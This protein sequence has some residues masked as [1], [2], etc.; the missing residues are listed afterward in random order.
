[1][2]P[3]DDR[4]MGFEIFDRAPSEKWQPYIFLVYIIQQNYF[5]DVMTY[6][7]KLCSNQVFRH[8]LVKMCRYYH[9]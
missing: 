6:I 9:I 4:N 5:R 7:K 1:M 2:D 8:I 3:R